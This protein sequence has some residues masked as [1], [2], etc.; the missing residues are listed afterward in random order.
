MGT[1]ISRGKCK[2]L[3][4]C[5]RPCP[6]PGAH[7]EEVVGT[8]VPNPQAQLE[9]QIPVQTD[10]QKGGAAGH[11]LSTVP[12]VIMT[13]CMTLDRGQMLSHLQIGTRLEP[14]S[15]R[16][17]GTCLVPKHSRCFV[18]EFPELMEID[19]LKLT[20]NKIHLQEP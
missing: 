2:A 3:W 14:E 12:A 8:S 18:L 11:R 19:L 7:G 17:P 1:Q 4:D 15:V 16:S 13:H 10:R 6:L 20:R 5:G 9:S